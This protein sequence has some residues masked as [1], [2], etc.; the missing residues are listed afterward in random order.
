MVLKRQWR[1]KTIAREVCA[2]IVI[3]VLLPL[4]R[5]QCEAITL[6]VDYSNG[7]GDWRWALTT[8]EVSGH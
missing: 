4:P 1:T 8:L 3:V 2:H 5:I 7:V 6:W